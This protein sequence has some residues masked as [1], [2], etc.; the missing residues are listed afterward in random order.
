MTED[1]VKKSI[2][3]SF[4]QLERSVAACSEDIIDHAINL[5]RHFSSLEPTDLDKLFRLTG[6]FHRECQ[7][8]KKTLL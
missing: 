7:C 8:D 6:Q 5:G 4:A 3:E 1:K 2:E